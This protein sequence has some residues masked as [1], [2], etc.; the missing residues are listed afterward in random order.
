MTE[1]E[2]QL[3]DLVM[4][5]PETVYYDGGYDYCQVCDATNEVNRDIEVTHKPDCPR[6]LVTRLYNETLANSRGY[7]R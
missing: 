4:S 5:Y 3:Y 7:N 2:T 1:L 6:I